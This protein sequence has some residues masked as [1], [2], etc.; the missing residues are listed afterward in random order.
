MQLSV[1]IDEGSSEG[2]RKFCAGVRDLLREVQ[3]PE[4]TTHTHTQSHLH[5]H[6]GTDTSTCT[7]T[8]VPVHT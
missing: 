6:T 8:D 3:I 1:A 2:L 7:D 4:Q 5:M